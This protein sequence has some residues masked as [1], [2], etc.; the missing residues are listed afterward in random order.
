MSGD[1]SS[2]LV[3]SLENLSD[4]ELVKQLK[5]HFGHDSFKSE[6][7]KKA[8]QTILKR[9]KDVFVSM[10]TGSGKSLCFQ[11][12]AVVYSKKVAV[13]FSPLLALMKD[14]LDHLN[15]RNIRAE[16]INSKM[17]NADKQRVI[18]DLKLKVP[19]TR[20]LYVTPEQAA[21]QTFKNILFDLFRYKKLSYMVVD[22]AHCVS[23][24]GHDFRPDY[25]KL[26]HLRTGIPGIPWVALTA[27][28]SKKVVEDIVSHLRLDHPSTFKTP[29]FRPNLFYDVI[30]EDLVEDS[31]THLA[32]FVQETLDEDCK[33]AGK[34]NRKER[35]EKGCGIIY[36]RTRILTEEVAT[37]LNRKGVSTVPYHAGLRDKERKQIQEDWTS[38]KYPVIAA[39]ISFGMGVD[40][41]TVRFV[42]H[43]GMAPSIPAYYQESGRAG[44]DGLPAR[45][46]VYHN[47]ATRKAIDFI[48]NQERNSAKS[49]KKEDQCKSAIK[50][51]SEMVDLLENAR[52]R[53][54]SLALH[55]GDEKPNCQKN[56]DVCSD[57]KAVE[58]AI[59]D[60][61]S[62]REYQKFG[63]TN[64]ADYVET[65]GD[66]YGE[67]RGGVSRDSEDYSNESSEKFGKDVN[68]T[69]D[70]DLINTIKEQFALRRSESCGSGNADDPGIKYSIVK[71]AEA[72]KI[73]V[74]G[75]SVQ[76]SELRKMT[77]NSAPHPL[78]LNESEPKPEEVTRLS[79]IV[80]SIEDKVKTE[81]EILDIA[82]KDPEVD[83]IARSEAAAPQQP[84]G[85][86]TAGD[87]MKILK[88]TEVISKVK[89]NDVEKGDKSGADTVGFH[90]MSE[91]EDEAEDSC[92]IEDF[93]NASDSKTK[94]RRRSTES[95]VSEESLNMQSFDVSPGV[96][97][98]FKL[99][100]D[101]ADTSPDKSFSRDI[102][103]V[104]I[105]IETVG[106]SSKEIL[107]SPVTVKT[108]ATRVSQKATLP[109]PVPPP[110]FPLNGATID[111]N[112]T[113][114]R[115][116]SSLFGNESDEESS[117]ASVK[118]EKKDKVPFSYSAPTSSTDGLTFNG[119]LFEYENENYKSWTH[120]TYNSDASSTYKADGTEISM[121]YVSG[122]LSGFL[123]I[124]SLTMGG[125]EIENQTFIE[126]TQEPGITFVMSKFD[127]I[128]GLAF[129][130][131]AAS[132]A[133][134]PFFNMV[135][136]KKSDGLFSF[137]LNRDSSSSPGGEIIFG[138]IDND[139]VDESTLKYVKL[140]NTTY[141]EFEM[142]GVSAQNAQV[143]C[144]GKCSAVADTGTSLIIGP[145]E[146]VNKIN[147][148]IGATTVG[149]VAMIDCNSID[150]LPNVTFNING[151]EYTLEPKDYVIK[152]TVLLQSA[153]IS[154][155]SGMD[156]PMIDW[157]LGD[158][159]IGKFYTVF[160]A[161]NQQVGFGRILRR[162]NVGHSSAK[163]QSHI[164]HRIVQFM[165]NVPTMQLVQH[166]VLDTKGVRGGEIV[167]GG[168]DDDLIDA[169][170]LHYIPVTNDTYWLIKMEGPFNSSKS[171][172]RGNPL[173]IT[174]ATNG[175]A[176][177]VPIPFHVDGKQIVRKQSLVEHIF[178]YG[179]IADHSNCGEGQAEHSVEIE[180]VEPRHLHE[181]FG[182]RLVMDF[183]RPYLL[184]EL[185]D[186][187]LELHRGKLSGKSPLR[188]C[189]FSSRQASIALS[190]RRVRASVLLPA[191]EHLLTIGFEKISSVN[192][193]CFP[194]IEEGRW[195][196]NLESTYWL[197]HI[198]N[199]IHGAGRIVDKIETHKTSVLVHCSDGWDRTV[200][201]I[202]HGDNNHSD[203][204]RSPVFLQFIDCVWQVTQQLTNAF[205]FNDCFLITIID[206]LYSCR[207]GTF[208]YN[209]EKERMANQV[210]QN[211]ISLWSYINSNIDLYK[212]PLYFA[213][214]QVLR[215]IASMRHIRLWR[216]LYCRWN[217]T[218]RP[219]RTIR[220]K[221]AMMNS[222]DSPKMKQTRP[223]AICSRSILMEKAPPA[224][225]LTSPSQAK[226]T[227]QPNK[228]C[229]SA[230][231]SS[232]AA[233]K[234]NST[235]GGASS[236]ADNSNPP[237]L[238]P[239]TNSAP[240]PSRHLYSQQAPPI[241]GTV[242]TWLPSSSSII[243]VQNSSSTKA[244]TLATTVV[245][246]NLPS[247]TEK[248]QKLVKYG[249]KSYILVA[250]HNVINV[251][252]AVVS[253]SANES[254]TEQ[255]SNNGI[256]LVPM[257][258]QPPPDSTLSDTTNDKIHGDLTAVVETTNGLSPRS[259]AVAKHSVKLVQLPPQYSPMNFN[260]MLNAV[261]KSMLSIFQYLKV[262]ELLRATQACK[263]W[264]FI[265]THHSLWE[266]VKMKNSK[267]CD[268]DGFGKT[269]S[270]HNTRTL[271]LRKMI[272]PETP[273]ATS[274]MWRKMADTIRTLPRLQQI[275]FGRCTPSAIEAVAG[276]CPQ[277]ESIVS[278]SMRGTEINM[279]L[280]ANCQNL[281]ELKL[282]S[283]GG[284]DV[285]NITAL[286]QLTK[287]KTL[288]L[289]TVKNLEGVEN[290][291]PEGLENLEL[292]E[293]V[294]ISEK[295]ATAGLAKLSKLRRLRLERGQG[296]NCPTM[297]LVQ[298]VSEL[299]NLAQ[300]EL[301]NFDIKPGFDRN[302]AKCSNIKVL[303]IIPTYVTQ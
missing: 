62:A 241:V 266:T 279:S 202:G 245:T 209:S 58:R 247:A 66:L 187:F 160:D 109:T 200:Q 204:D 143:G 301:I 289:T 269:L 292:G 131:I 258:V 99:A 67:G 284:F 185:F 108:P 257:S 233:S 246:S 287:L 13:V 259:S 54:W 193:I 179:H 71:A 96:E 303:L 268:F 122:S 101:S 216:G 22:E 158:V 251:D 159:F 112:S 79:Q 280:L 7:Q 115:K 262:H 194:V 285:K 46:R 26:G 151:V 78:I 153:C 138:G 61:H 168:I 299:P 18:N 198:K 64:S 154:G 249:D 45:C 47:K 127:G 189:G 41:A 30:Y 260:F 169:A 81:D 282:K 230:A 298:T 84:S 50:A 51:Y 229:P 37:V 33:N 275:D 175:N 254:S 236:A 277:L 103:G 1:L 263:N 157:I 129:P 38:G 121:S 9:K 170:D 69:K 91:S 297:A 226:R 192:E 173:R 165:D 145:T 255:Q 205:E 177:L 87:I 107:P 191:T 219:Q 217:P 227:P 139:I 4:D 144:N 137:Y 105:D 271:D 119:S 140:T 72:T 117:E 190:F 278:L 11:L 100:K 211:T 29:C 240:T 239:I 171:Q 125:V 176:G 34:E 256:L 225:S 52:C 150:S 231:T 10:P 106:H 291:L 74:A 40:K 224:E 128:L 136:Q 218:M 228:S 281:V 111:G 32:E 14:Q 152:L 70:R 294:K 113:L 59:S 242:T 126:A 155:F 75:L 234:S 94:S 296:S 65:F 223:G 235:A 104:P 261:T 60:F 63:L 167:F 166:S 27:T 44:R 288:A 270:K 212:N 93:P 265:A 110:A 2:F 232:S 163:I 55:F 220:A 42:I 290:A 188:N 133:Q 76:V 180:R 15:K 250:R 85:F 302:I 83:T 146:E 183:Q 24:W 88:K 49:K 264:H 276:S 12:P 184:R 35:A 286:K 118:R 39:T 23:Q 36:C 142:N 164:R 77:E 123:S 213:K 114:K 102:D 174:S 19:N 21:T 206:H 161:T 43:W 222:R 267:I 92:I 97:D 56:C 3:S 134:P 90:A 16:T 124:D 5:K 130:A 53:H 141:W 28:A 243:Q 238:V 17:S 210:K 186:K 116:Y 293:C 253:G 149:S 57:Q 95:A 197:K 162:N 181:T 208:L 199:I 252:Q 20:L 73:K 203:A 300:L 221:I 273:E 237:P 120:K 82:K 98:D 207:F 86:M 25:L 195:F 201:R 283:F 214:Q 172:T 48:L 295:F 80:K 6:L 196:S 244:S 215:P 135:A 182:E 272:M 156:L 148:A 178:V 89:S 8:V 31:Y 248:P 147:A 274:E 68:E 132:K